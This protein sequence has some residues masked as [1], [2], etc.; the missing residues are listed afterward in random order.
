MTAGRAVDA[1]RSG[2]RSALGDR[3]RS[4]GPDRTEALA[5]DGAALIE[6]VSV[7]VL[8]DALRVIDVSQP[9]HASFEGFLDG[10]QRSTTIAYVDGVPLLHGTAAAA[11]R[12][13]D[14]AG[15]LTTW[16][17]PQIEHAVYAS[18]ALIGDETWAQLVHVLDARGHVVRDTDDGL[19]VPSRHPSAL[20][21]Q[22]YD[23]LSRVRNDMERAVGESWCDAHADRPLYVDGSVRTSHA[24]LR[25]TGVIGVVKS[26]ATLYLPDDALATVTA[27]GAGQRTSV[28]AALDATGRPRFFTWYLRLRSA[29]GRDPF[30]GLIRV[31]CGTRSGDADV[32]ERHAD[33]TSAWLLAERA[34]LARPDAR[35]D[36]MP[37]AIRD[38]EVYLRAVA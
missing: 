19:P 3:V 18:R 36:V 33:R 9:P 21:R 7:Q 35:W 4:A 23:A 24:M 30:F 22:A 25:S 2:L 29:V 15:R 10:I 8:G 20:L 12:A 27:L 28:L 14:A 37:Y 34:P 17:A 5:Q 26:H 6:H 31:E 38:C 32:A 1:A 16:R 11:I 13:R